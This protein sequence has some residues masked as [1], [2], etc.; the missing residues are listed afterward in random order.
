M[1]L[2]VYFHAG[3]RLMALLLFVYLAYWALREPGFVREHLPRLVLFAVVAFAIAAPLLRFFQ[4]HPNDM[5]APWTRRAIFPSGWVDET[6]KATGKSVIGILFMQFLKS[7]LAFNY[8]YDPVFHYHPQIPLLHF[9]PSIFFVY[10][11]TYALLH[12]RERRFFLM[13]LWFV[14]VIIFGGTLLENPP[15]SHRLLLAIPPVLMCVAVGMVK[16]AAYLVS[17][18]G[19]HQRLGRVITLL[20][21]LLIGYQSAHFY[22]AQY[23]P[24]LEYAGHNTHVADRMGKYL[25]YL[26]P[27]Y[28]CYFFGA[29]RMYFGFS[30]ITYLA[31]DVEGVDVQNPLTTPP[32]P[33]TLQ[34]DKL[35]VFIFLPERE[36]ELDLVRQ[37]FPSG[38]LRQFRDDRG[39]LLFV[40]YEADAQSSGP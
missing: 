34:P 27:G 33:E 5:M 28:R 15:S 37:T 12:W 6:V 30:T 39:Q 1:G 18:F 17:L 3:S 24:S 8:Y 32:G 4:T 7:V 26:G 22:F 19:L 10:G 35:P 25:R 9:V 13:V 16:I 29:P 20:L 2:S 36:G 31:R 23:T 40:A 11:L 21:T 38:L 14:M